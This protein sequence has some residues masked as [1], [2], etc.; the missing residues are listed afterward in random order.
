MSVTKWKVVFMGTPLFA[1]PVLEKLIENEDVIA[2]YTQ[3]DRP[4]GR[5]QKMTPPPVKTVAQK[6]HIPCFQPPHFKKASTIEELKSL[7]PDL[8]VIIAYGLFLPK[9]VLDI[10]PHQT[11]NVHPSL[12]PQYRGAAPIQWA[13]INGDAQTGVTILY[14][15]PEMDAGDILMQKKVKISDEDT[16]DSLQSK[17]CILG[18]DLLI[19]TLGGL[20]HHTITPRP[21][22]PPKNSK[23]I[24]LSPKL[25]KEI[26]EID[27]TKPARTLFNLIR[28]ANPWPGTYTYLQGELLKIHS[29]KVVS[30]NFQGKAGKIH[31]MTEGGLVIETP[32]GLLLL[33]EVQKPN[34]RK[35]NASEFLKGQR[36][37]PG[38]YL[39]TQKNVSS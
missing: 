14:V 10:P 4:S 15:T 1:I 7:H 21:Q 27:W 16:A 30:E 6:H 34:K 23:E 39:G 2:V 38:S 18:A 12:L 5:G 33:T 26:S 19:E 13:L 29:A 36:I 22:N 11:L 35:M 24:S 25:S 28:G 17:L 32:Q 9:S 8:I 31:S 37:K 20:K 3:P